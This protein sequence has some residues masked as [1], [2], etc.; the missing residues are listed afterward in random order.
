MRIP[1]HMIMKSSFYLSFQCSLLPFFISMSLAAHTTW[2]Y[3]THASFTW[4]LLC[5]TEQ[6]RAE[7]SN[8]QLEG[9]AREENTH[10]LRIDKTRSKIWWTSKTNSSFNFQ[11]L[12]RWR[13]L[14]IRHQKTTKL[15]LWTFDVVWHNIF[16]SSEIVT[17]YD[18]WTSKS[19][20]F[21]DGRSKIAHF[22]NTLKVTSIK[23]LPLWQKKFFT[24]FI[25]QKGEVR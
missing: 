1:H 25:P 4:G 22:S 7:D 5:W 15:N 20:L 17:L 14:E 21:F 3:S 16:V 24:S 18:L 19:H 9:R 12:K 10:H 8:I 13:P 11:L 2:T 6:S 23:L